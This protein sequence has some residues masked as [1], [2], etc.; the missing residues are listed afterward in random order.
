MEPLDKYIDKFQ[1]AY[2]EEFREE[3]SKKE[4]F[5]KFLR[6]VNFLRVILRPASGKEQGSRHPAPVSSG[7]DQRFENDK[8]KEHFH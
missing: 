8:L 1:Q 5:E 6:L 7:F 4:A 2:F 3:I